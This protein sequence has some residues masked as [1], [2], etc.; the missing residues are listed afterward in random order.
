MWGWRGGGGRRGERGTQFDAES[1]VGKGKR[2]KNHFLPLLFRDGRGASALGRTPVLHTAGMNR[3]P[4]LRPFFSFF[5]EPFLHM[6]ASSLGAAASDA[7]E[8]VRLLTVNDDSETTQRRLPNIVAE[9]ANLFLDH[10]QYRLRGVWF[11]EGEHGASSSRSRHLR[12]DPVTG[13]RGA[14]LINFR[15]PYPQGHQ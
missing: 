8:D 6:P 13:H 11:Q 4:F 5:P 3:P 10:I 12:V 2:R 9:T 1:L 7:R 14:D 15:M